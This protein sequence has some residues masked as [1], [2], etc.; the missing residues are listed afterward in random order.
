MIMKQD[1]GMDNGVR[2]TKHSRQMEYQVQRWWWWWCGLRKC[3]KFGELGQNIRA[4]SGQRKG[5]GFGAG[6]PKSSMDVNL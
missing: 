4:K 6:Q 1:G 5:G 3:V 2:W